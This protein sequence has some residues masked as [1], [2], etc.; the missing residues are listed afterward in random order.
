MVKRLILLLSLA[1]V[2]CGKL[3]MANMFLPLAEDANTRVLESMAW[4]KSAGVTTLSVPSDSYRW[5]VCADIHVDDTKPARFQ[6]MVD[7]ERTDSE[8]FFYQVLGDMLFGTE[9]LDLV[10]DI[11]YAPGNDPCFVLAGNHDIYFG[12]WDAWKAVFHSSTYY[13][14]VQ[15]PAYRDLYI[16]LDSANGTLGEVQLSWL[17]SVLENQR[18]G[19]RHCI[20]SVHTNILRTDASQFPSTNF[21]MEETYR[22][23]DAMSSAGVEMMIAGHDH[24]R[25]V[26]RYNGVTYITLDAI[27]ERFPTAS[28]MVVNMGQSIDY[29][30]VDADD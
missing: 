5:Y 6:R 4:N 26:T 21:T 30:F 20:V 12:G 11:V 28:Y 2:S 14:Y 9:H 18:P 8:S 10:S 15:T 3:D 25:D 1:A 24:E 7:A 29:Q 13:Y 27:G 16:M 17:D 22:L 23:L 19:C